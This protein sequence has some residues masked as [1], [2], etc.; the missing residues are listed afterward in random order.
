MKNKALTQP[1]EKPFKILKESFHATE[2]YKLRLILVVISII[3][4]AGT[5][6]IGI[7]FTKVLIDDYI[8]P[9]VLQKKS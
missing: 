7:S 4:S 2:E 6:A 9:L 1:V 3:I 8:A 5:N